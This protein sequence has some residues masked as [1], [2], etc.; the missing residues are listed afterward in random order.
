MET[1]VNKKLTVEDVLRIKQMLAENEKSG[2]EIAEIFNV[3]S[4]MISHIKSGRSWAD[5]KIVQPEA[6]NELVGVS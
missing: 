4:G 6:S 5:V 1:K 2:K 3:T